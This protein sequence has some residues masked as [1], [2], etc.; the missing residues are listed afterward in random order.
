MIEYSSNA[1]QSQRSVLQ[2]G[3]T[4]EIDLDRVSVVCSVPKF[5][6]VTKP[7]TQLSLGRK[8]AQWSTLCMLIGFFVPGLYASS[9]TYCYTGNFFTFAFASPYTTADRITGCFTAPAI[10]DGA[11]FLAVDPTSYSF[12]DGV[13]V[14]NNSNSFPNV[15]DFSTDPI[16][17]AITNWQIQIWTPDGIANEYPEIDSSKNGPG[18]SILG[19]PRAAAPVQSWPTNHVLGVARPSLP[20]FTSYHSD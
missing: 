2:R 17:G 1:C 4:A 11:T 19:T 3:R 14:L 18:G 9:V 13:D 6:P 7:A 5:M 12:T 16:T 15:F 20:P 10:P 8:H